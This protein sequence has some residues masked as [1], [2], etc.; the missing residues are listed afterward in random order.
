MLVFQFGNPQVKPFD[1]LEGEEMNLSQKLDDLGLGWVHARIMAVVG[2]GS[3]AGC[4]DR[5]LNPARHALNH[6]STS[7]RRYRT[8]API[9]KYFGLV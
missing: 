7:S 5:Q 8:A 6:D 3:G 2:F 1:F 9:F 4:P